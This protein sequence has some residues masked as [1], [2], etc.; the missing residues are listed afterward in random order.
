MTRLIALDISTKNTGWAIYED[1]IYKESGVIYCGQIR[2]T[3]K[4][5][6]EMMYFIIDKIDG[7][8]PD[9]C[10][11]EQSILGNRNPNSFRELSMILGAVFYHCM[12]IG[13]SYY[14]YTPSEW[15]KLID[16]GKKPRKREE[17]KKWDI[18]KA[19][20][21]YSKT[22]QTDDEADAILIGAAYINMWDKQEKKNENK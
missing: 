20:E 10:V 21:L 6:N 17:L 5:I 7:C 1:G 4:R 2:E 19:T 11:V 8:I 16:P 18:D 22:L 14:T 15:R 13:T 3:D 12:E 9:I